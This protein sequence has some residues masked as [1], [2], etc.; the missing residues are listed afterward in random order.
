MQIFCRQ[1]IFAQPDGTAVQEQSP[2]K[3][4]I[5][6]D[7]NFKRKKFY[8]KDHFLS[9]VITPVN[10]DDK[11]HPRPSSHFH[12]SGRSLYTPG[13]NEKLKV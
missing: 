8:I 4:L 6:L 5:F 2:F 9:Y 12:L 10:E 1:A 11:P 3:T 7:I 13:F